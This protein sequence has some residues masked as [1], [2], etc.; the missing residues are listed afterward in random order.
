MAGKPKAQFFAGGTFSGVGA[1]PEIVAALLAMGISRPS[2]IQA[3]AY[4]GLLSDAAHLVVGD[5]SGSGKTLAYLAPLVQLLRQ[6]EAEADGPVTVP[7]C[8]RVLIVVPTEELCQQV[9][10]V[11]KALT[12]GA[13]LRS[14]LLTGGRPSRTQRDLLDQGVDIVVATP[15]RAADMVESGHLRLDVCRAVVLDEADLLLSDVAA[16][17]E[18]IAPLR[19]A[20]PQKTRFVLVTATLPAELFDELQNAFPGIGSALGPALHRSAPG[21]V[22]QVIDCSGGDDISEESGGKRKA[23]ALL[24]V[25]RAQESQRTVV[26][27]NK[28]ETCRKVENL[29]TRT[30]RRSPPSRTKAPPRGSANALASIIRNNDSDRFEYDDAEGGLYG[31]ASPQQDDR[32]GLA[33]SSGNTAA[34]KWTVL[35]YHSAISP[36][37]RQDNL[38]AFSQPPQSGDPPAVLV[39]TDR[40]SRGIDAP[41]VGHVVLFDFPRDPS[42]Y[43]RRAGRTARGATGRG[44]VSLLVLGRQVRLA[45]DIVERNAKGAP[46]HKVPVALVPAGARVPS[47]AE[48]AAAAAA[49]QPLLIQDTDEELS[50][51]EG[52]GGSPV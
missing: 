3:A 26:F 9:A 38:L 32:G 42:E 48:V 10:R 20:A 43:V 22:E 33:S 35:P 30:A 51:H 6:E 2:H 14:M 21:V 19:N 27:C 44:V 49:G 31:T 16:F 29:L 17:S 1:S 18:Q 39:T 47:R 40:L 4:R 13:P 15:Q 12:A 5:H 7:N 37:Q 45:Y 52:H 46:I 24:Q 34:K 28:I 36:E 50:E 41:G 25:L 8:P 23:A 11:V